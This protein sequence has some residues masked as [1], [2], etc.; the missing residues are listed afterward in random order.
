MSILPTLPVAMM[1]VQQKGDGGKSA[2]PCTCITCATFGNL[3]WFKPHP[4]Q[5]KAAEFSHTPTT[6]ATEPCRAESARQM[7]YQRH[8]TQTRRFLNQK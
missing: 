7:R 1:T 3:L 4:R 5:A 6:L 8:D 2:C